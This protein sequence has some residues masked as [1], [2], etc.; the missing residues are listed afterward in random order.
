M[1]NKIMIFKVKLPIL[2]IDKRFNVRY[3]TAP[4][5]VIVKSKTH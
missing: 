5:I 4:A 1:E 3:Q 2:I